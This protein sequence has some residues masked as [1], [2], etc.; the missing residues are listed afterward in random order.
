MMRRTIRSRC[1]QRNSMR[2]L[3][4]ALIALGGALAFSQAMPANQFA[5]QPDWWRKAVIYE[6]YP[7]SFG[8][9]N[10]DG[11]GDLKGI[12]EHLDYLQQLDRKSRRVGKECRS[13]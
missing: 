12:T 9:S 1:W 4:T 8:D 11:T 6:I 2:R 3:W 7:R 13:R 5:E 10:N